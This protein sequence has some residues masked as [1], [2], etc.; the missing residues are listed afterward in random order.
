MD[1]IE[2]EKKIQELEELC[3]KLRGEHAQYYNEERGWDKY[4]NTWESKT[5]YWSEEDKKGLWVSPEKR[6]EQIA[7]CK[8]KGAEV[9]KRLYELERHLG[10]LKAGVLMKGNMELQKKNETKG[11]KSKLSALYYLMKKEVYIPA[12]QFKEKENGSGYGASQY[13]AKKV[14]KE[15]KKKGQ[16]KSIKNIIDAMSRVKV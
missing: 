7:E 8:R 1:I 5:K 4:E 2:R 16:K 11:E 14:Q 15:M 3:M 9:F 10:E 12:R 13:A 6:K